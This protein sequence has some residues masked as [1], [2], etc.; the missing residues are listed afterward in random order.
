MLVGQRT[1]EVVFVQRAPLEQQRPDAASG[2]V[3]DA[4]RAG[5]VVLRDEIGSHEQL[6][7]SRHASADYGAGLGKGGASE[8]E[9]LDFL[10]FAKR[11]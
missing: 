9:P 4:E 10:A 7:Q 5:E 6:S 3:L 8:A 1:A 2:E 11:E